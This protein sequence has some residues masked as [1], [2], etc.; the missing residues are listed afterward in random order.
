[1]YIYDRQVVA[2]KFRQMD[3]TKKKNEQQ[4]RMFELSKYVCMYVENID[5]IL[6]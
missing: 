5:L 6:K 3:N 4:L 1:M 2:H